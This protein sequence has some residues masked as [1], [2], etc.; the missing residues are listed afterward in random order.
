MQMPSIGIDITI[1]ATLPLTK[2]GS[3]KGLLNKSTAQAEIGPL[4]VLKAREFST[5]D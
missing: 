2:E 4:T 5:P 1:G 3:T